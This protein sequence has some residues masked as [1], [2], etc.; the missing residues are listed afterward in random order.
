MKRNLMLSLL[1]LLFSAT[2]AQAQQPT[3]QYHRAWDKDGINVFEPS[4]L[5]FLYKN[6]N[7]ERIALNDS[8][9]A[10][11]GLSRTDK[12]LSECLTPTIPIKGN[13]V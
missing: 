11:F 5:C 13:C 4:I 10:D 2:W 8:E 3:I 1:A 6:C 12:L 9:S 7:E